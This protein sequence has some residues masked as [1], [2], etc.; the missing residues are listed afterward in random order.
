VPGQALGHPEEPVGQQFAATDCPRL[1]QQDQEGRLKSILGR[2]RVAQGAA[3]DAQHHRPVPFDQG[4][5]R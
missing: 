5:K 3:A 4:G 2:M 1:A